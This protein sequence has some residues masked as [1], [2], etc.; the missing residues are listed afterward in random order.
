LIRDAIN[1]INSGLDKEKLN[2]LVEPDKAR[3][4]LKVMEDVSDYMDFKKVI[5]LGL[6]VDHRDL[7]F[8][9]VILYSWIREELQNV[10]ENR[11]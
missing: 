2:E 6:R 5:D 4:I 8:D 1:A 9:R 3:N 7:S 11:V 10:R